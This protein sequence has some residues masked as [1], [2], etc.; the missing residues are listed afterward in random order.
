MGEERGMRG[1]WR[2]GRSC[3]IGS[4]PD[5]HLSTPCW[6]A[7]LLFDRRVLATAF[8]VG[9]NKAVLTYCCTT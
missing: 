4:S 8:I 2:Y 1:R 3:F 5:T 9:G 6:P 7:D